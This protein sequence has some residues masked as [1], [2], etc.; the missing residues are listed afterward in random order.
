METQAM[1]RK[2]DGGGVNN[3]CYKP[4]VELLFWK[5]PQATKHKQDGGVVND[6][7]YKPNVELLILFWKQPQAMKLK[8]DGGGVNDLCRKPN[9]KL[10]FWNSPGLLPNVNKAPLWIW[11]IM[12]AGAAN[13]N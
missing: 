12:A 1:E 8:Q 13:L 7:C 9:Y 3:L 5:Q 11:N 4:N 6:L 2:Q 10:L